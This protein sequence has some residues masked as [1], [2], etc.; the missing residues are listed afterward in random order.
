MGYVYSRE[1]IKMYSSKPI[2]LMLN[3]DEVD[4]LIRAMKFYE[5]SLADKSVS[6]V[7]DA[8]MSMN[9]IKSSLA[10]KIDADSVTLVLNANETKAVL[11]SFAFYSKYLA[12]KKPKGY[13]SEA[14]NINNMTEVLKPYAKH[15]KF[16]GKLTG[17]I[18]TILIPVLIKKGVEGAF[19]EVPPSKGQI[20]R[21]IAK[22]IKKDTKNPTW[23]G[24][25]V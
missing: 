19:K 20:N 15:L 17:I 2:Q 4:T 18:A 5:D 24:L 13:H 1:N 21:T 6:S 8:I 14:K 7:Q 25:V 11:N 23:E 3:S 10:N 16:I 9:N 22:Q 12:D